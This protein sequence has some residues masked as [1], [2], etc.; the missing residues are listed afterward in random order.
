VWT[1]DTL[2]K[3]SMRTLQATVQIRA[4]VPKGTILSATGRV[5]DAAHSRARAGLGTPVQ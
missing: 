2:A 5:E 3:Q 1:L 4:D